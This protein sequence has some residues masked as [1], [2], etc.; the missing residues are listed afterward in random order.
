MK[1]CVKMSA[2]LL[3]GLSMPLLAVGQIDF[4]SDFSGTSPWNFDS[5]TDPQSQVS[6]TGQFEYSF[7]ATNGSS[8]VEAALTPLAGKETGTLTVSGTVDLGSFEFGSSDFDKRTFLEIAT[9]N[10]NKSPFTGG[11]SLYTLGVTGFN[12][13][14]EF[15]FDQGLAAG[16]GSGGIERTGA[17]TVPA[18]DPV[19]DFEAVISISGDATSGWTVDATTTYTN[20]TDGTMDTTSSFNY[21]GGGFDGFQ[22]ISA[23][24][25]GMDDTSSPT[26]GTFSGDDLSVVPE[27]SMYALFLGGASFLGLGLFRRKAPRK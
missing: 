13:P 10:G 24:R 11:G 9:S 25:F 16:F 22:D 12:N 27:P 1:N 18:G 5:L 26:S 14:G 8:F 19:Y 15:R 21:S 6:G 4:T 20:A 17:F 7:A 3:S 23:V 2:L